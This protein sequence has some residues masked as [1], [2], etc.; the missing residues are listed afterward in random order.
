MDEAKRGTMITYEQFKE[1]YNAI[2]GSPEF[3]IFLDGKCE[4]GYMIIK[5]NDGPTFQKCFAGSSYEERKIGFASLDKLYHATMPDGICLERDWGR[6]TRVMLGDVFRLEIPEDLQDCWEL[7][8][9][10]TAKWKKD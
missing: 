1:P 9:P 3:P 4:E 6:V 8:A 10:L 2:G 7:Y 5:Y